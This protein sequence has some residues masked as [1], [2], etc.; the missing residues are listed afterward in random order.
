MGMLARWKLG[1]IALNVAQWAADVARSIDPGAV[2]RVLV[3]VLEIERE[4]RGVPGQLKLSELLE[5]F[6][7]N[8]PTAGATFV[9]IGYVRALV[10]LLNAL[11]VFRK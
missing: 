7:A 1:A 5:W 10:E 4:R 2:V 11:V 8:Y 6:T 3:K 9:V